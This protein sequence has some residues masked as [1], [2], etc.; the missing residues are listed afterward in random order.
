MR[1]IIDFVIKI[2]RKNNKFSLLVQR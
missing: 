2:A 1:I